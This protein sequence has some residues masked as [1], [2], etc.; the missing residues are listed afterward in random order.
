MLFVLCKNI[1]TN[2]VH[3][4]TYLFILF[5][6]NMTITHL[7]P[8]RLRTRKLCS[9][10]FDP[11][12]IRQAPGQR[13]FMLRN[14]TPKPYKDPEPEV[15]TQ[16]RSPSPGIVNL[17]SKLYIRCKILKCLSTH[18]RICV[19]RLVRVDVSRIWSERFL[20]GS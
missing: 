9:D 15:N 13:V 17:F 19:D 8:E 12:F 10:H 3:L 11:K 4:F 6:G 20:S 14:S 5:L 7:P 16:P 2:H 18:I 1:S